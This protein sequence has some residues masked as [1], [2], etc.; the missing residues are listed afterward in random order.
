MAFNEQRGSWAGKSE[1]PGKD[2]EF[3][4]FF[5]RNVFNGFKGN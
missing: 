1:K 5:S 3:V 4:K 2:R